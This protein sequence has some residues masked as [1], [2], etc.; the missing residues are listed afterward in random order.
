MPAFNVDAESYVNLVMQPILQRSLDV[1][2]EQSW[3]QMET[4]NSLA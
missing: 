2:Q 3:V 4:F 1:K